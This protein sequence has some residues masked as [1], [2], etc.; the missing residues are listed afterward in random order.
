[1]F[2]LKSALIIRGIDLHSSEE[3]SNC[4]LLRA[5]VYSEVNKATAAATIE[6]FKA[7]GAQLKEVFIIS[8]NILMSY[9]A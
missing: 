8:Q 6:T 4:E 7:T 3:K 1:M 2:Q 9:L 5:A